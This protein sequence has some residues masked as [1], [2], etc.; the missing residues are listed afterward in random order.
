MCVKNL[1]C[2][3]DILELETYILLLIKCG[4]EHLSWYLKSEEV[5]WIDYLKIE[6]ARVFFEE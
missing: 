1:E 5:T 4:I 3:L 2:A 6:K